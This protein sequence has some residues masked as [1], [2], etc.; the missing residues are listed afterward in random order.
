MRTAFVRFG[1]NFVREHF[2][3]PLEH[4]LFG[5]EQILFANIVRSICT[6]VI[7]RYSDS[8]RQQTKS[9]YMEESHYFEE[10]LK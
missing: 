8:F 4:F 2:L 7:P 1:T 9:H 6:T 5:L 3:F 10:S